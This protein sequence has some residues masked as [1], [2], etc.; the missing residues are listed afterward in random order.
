MRS[1]VL[2]LILI[3]LMANS[4]YSQVFKEGEYNPKTGIRCLAYMQ[5]ENELY[6][7]LDFLLANSSRTKMFDAYVTPFHSDELC[8]N[9]DTSIV[10]INE[11][12]S[13]ATYPPEHWAEIRH[14]GDTVKMLASSKLNNVI[15]KIIA[16]SDT[17]SC[18]YSPFF[19]FDSQTYEVRISE[20]NSLSYYKTLF[21]YLKKKNE[22]AKQSDDFMLFTF[23]KNSISELSYFL[24]DTLSCIS[25]N[26]T[27]DFLDFRDEVLLYSIKEAYNAV[28]IVDKKMA[29]FSEY[30]D[31]MLHQLKNNVY[32][33]QK[34][35][36]YYKNNM[37]DYSVVDTVGVPQIAKDEALKFV[38]KGYD[39]YDFDNWEHILKENQYKYPDMKNQRDKMIHIYR[40]LRKYH[41]EGEPYEKAL[42]Q[43]YHERFEY[44]VN[45]DLVRIA[46][47][48][49]IK[50]K[51]KEFLDI[52][53]ENRNE[54]GKYCY[55]YYGLLDSFLNGYK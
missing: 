39:E 35:W 36:E 43:Y 42:A 16:Y 24:Y 38:Q 50:Y 14:K 15:N 45:D 20:H 33:P 7:V 30:R 48:Y 25:R 22:E 2:S 47:I 31:L 10:L 46:M 26:Y 27:S 12:A 29:R 37:I 53:L 23:C 55:F 9:K 6:S 41:V 5:S 13:W 19:R 52:L 17:M 18:R 11:T 21:Q 40:S 54:W 32:Y 34:Y 1:V 44:I 4:A 28:P 51:D 49:A 3:G 8:I